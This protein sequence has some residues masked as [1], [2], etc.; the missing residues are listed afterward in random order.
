MLSNHPA[1]RHLLRTIAK[2]V[3]MT[4]VVATIT[5]VVVRALP[6]NPVDIFIQDLVNGGMPYADAR[7]RATSILRLD[8]DAPLAAQY[9]AY[10]GNLI[11]LDFG[12]S[13][14]I[15]RGKTVAEV[16]WSRLPWTLF[17]VGISLSLSFWLGLKLGL[18]AAYRRNSWLDHLITNVSSAVDAVP[19]VLLAVLAV[20]FLGVTWKIVPI[21][22]MRGAYGATV[23]PG[24]SLPFAVSALTHLVIPGAV[25]IVSSL[26]AWILAMRSN[27]IGV[28]GDDYVTMARARGLSEKRVR[29]AYV[30]RNARLPLV[31]AFAIALGFTVGGS[32]LIEQIFV[33]PGIGYTLAQAVARRD[34]PVMQGIL[35][36][37]TVCVL[38]AVAVADALYGWLDPRIRQPAE[39][40]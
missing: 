17:S 2:L 9:F 21:D 40:M 35:I 28:L 32:V 5:F 13:Y 18:L 24:L 27:T 37:T 10:L 6:G 19:A 36:V 34:Y 8:V 30:G 14:V 25:Y 12:D 7:H 22:L 39:R 23:K 15:A 31:T 33:Y 3:F 1:L 16:I 20:L 4:W 11:H 38:V 29:E 26:G